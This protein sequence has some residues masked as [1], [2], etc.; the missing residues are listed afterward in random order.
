MK[1]L[2]MIATA[3]FFFSGFVFAHDGDKGK[4]KDKG[5]KTSVKSCPGKHC[6]KKS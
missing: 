4:G 3:A 6:G 5:K 1:K 2:M